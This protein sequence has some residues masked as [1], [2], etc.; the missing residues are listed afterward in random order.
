MHGF[1]AKD[2]CMFVIVRWDDL[3]PVLD[4]LVCGLF[5]ELLRYCCLRSS[6]GDGFHDAEV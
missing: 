4:G 5:G 1:F 2:F 6:S 3:V